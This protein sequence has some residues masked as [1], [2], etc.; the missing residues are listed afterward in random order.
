MAG[1]L[2]A[3]VLSAMDARAEG[4]A[5]TCEDAAQLAVLPSPIAPWKGAPLRVVIAVERPIEGALSLIAPD[6][7]VAASSRERHGGPPYFWFAEVA[8]PAAGTWRATLARDRAPAECS[9]ITR[10]IVVR[11]DRPAPPSA[12][13]GSV[14]PLRN[15]WNRATE[16][17]YSAWIEIL[18]DAP[19]DTE[20][21]WPALHEVLRDR[22]R[23]LLFNHLGLGEDSMKIVLRPDCA[24]L[25]YFLRAYFAFK[26]GLPFGYSK[27]SRGGGGKAPYCPQWWNIQNLEPPPPPPPPPEQAA[28]R[29][30]LLQ[31]PKA[32]FSA[33][34][35]AKLRH[36]HRARLRQSP[37]A[38]LR[39]SGWGSRRRSASILGRSAMESI[40]AQRERR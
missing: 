20:L 7:R 35:S 9:T 25:P 8:S 13:E 4:S 36:P 14:W 40:P 33:M 26:M 23:N 31:I 22:S 37:Q 34:G 1:A 15:A 2:L 27:C 39:P 12:P 19:L 10:E 29:G 21:S 16:N 11:A 32:D 17:L 6:G 30:R 18:F 3:F 24:D 38:H 28:A 5:G